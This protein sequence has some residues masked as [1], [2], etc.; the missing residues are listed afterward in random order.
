MGVYMYLNIFVL[1]I[2]SNLMKLSIAIGCNAT[3]SGF[4][5]VR[6]RVNL[7]DVFF[8]CVFGWSHCG[9]VARRINSDYSDRTA[10]LVYVWLCR[11]VRHEIKQRIRVVLYYCVSWVFCSAVCHHV[12][13]LQNNCLLVF[14]KFTVFHVINLDASS[15]MLSVGICHCAVVRMICLHCGWFVFC[16]FAG[17]HVINSGYFRWVINYCHCC[18]IV[19]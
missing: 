16:Y 15:R 4:E 19:Q 5:T 9:N 1:V 3:R 18:S 14:C 12:L 6:N 2:A 11:G 8:W 7:I 13:L 10:G 17:Y